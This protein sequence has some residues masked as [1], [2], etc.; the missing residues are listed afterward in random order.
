MAAAIALSGEQVGA[1]AT[2]DCIS[3]A[4]R[5][6]PH[7]RVDADRGHARRVPVAGHRRGKPWPGQP[8]LHYIDVAHREHA[9]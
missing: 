9:V 6:S 3:P 4:P 8:S 7:A 1:P 2:L 5:G